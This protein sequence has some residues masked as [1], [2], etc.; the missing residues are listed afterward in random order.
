[1]G[2][3]KS[4]NGAIVYPRR[5]PTRKKE[6]KKRNQVQS[7]ANG[8]VYHVRPRGT[9]FKFLFAPGPY[10]WDPPVYVGVYRRDPF[11]KLEPQKKLERSFQ[12]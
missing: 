1:M 8:I 11:K 12:K 3:V 6:E 4:E 2:L 10:D 9:V 7:G 5:K